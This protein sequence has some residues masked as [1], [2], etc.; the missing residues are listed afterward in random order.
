MRNRL[1]AIASAFTFALTLGA[2]SRELPKKVV[3]PPPGIYSPREGDI[4]FQSLPHNE[5]IDAI[6]GCTN[7]PFSHCG[8][9]VFRKDGWHVLEAVGPVKETPLWQWLM[10]GREWKFSACRLKPEHQS[11][12]SAMIS[13]ARE[14]SG[15]PYD[16]QYEM[17]DEM[18]YCS[19]LIYKGF[20]EAG[21]GKLGRILML[22][23]LNWKPYERIIRA[24]EGGPVPL[25]REMITPEDLSMAEQLIVVLPF[26]KH[27]VSGGRK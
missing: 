12:I 25:N 3:S 14:F 15:R 26:G 17:D 7:S 20:L 1:A 6:E 22:G 13:A 2:L 16:I 21:G 10:Q 11:R 8:I 9:V 23:E 4:L 18:I 27:S 19:E 24:I 5:V